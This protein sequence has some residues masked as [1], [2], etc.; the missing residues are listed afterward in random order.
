MPCSDPDLDRETHR[1]L[2]KKSQALTDML[3]RVCKGAENSGMRLPNDVADW[4]ESTRRKMLG[5]RL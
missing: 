1:K 4:W 2:I 5:G 3:C